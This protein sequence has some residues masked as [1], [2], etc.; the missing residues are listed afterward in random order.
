MSG[1]SDTTA[2]RR[3]EILSE[4]MHLVRQGGLA[5][6]TMRKV[7]ARIGFTETAAYRY[8]PNK[9]SLLVGLADWLGEMLLEPIRV[10][11][12]S[13]ERPEERIRLILEHHIHFVLRLDG[14]P[15][16]VLAEAAATG[17]KEL[18]ERLA[19][20]VRDYLT[21]LSGVLVEMRGNDEPVRSEELALLLLGIPASLAIRRRLGLDREAEPRVHTELLPFVLRCLNQKG[22]AR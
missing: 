19:G 15:M 14:L 22:G 1:P 10:L 3:G 7:A 11:A 9:Q 17:E 8:F 12:T 20:I 5:N 2:D 21:L 4:A 18:L 6:L 16:L 13:D